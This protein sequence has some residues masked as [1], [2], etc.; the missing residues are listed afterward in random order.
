MKKETLKI[1]KNWKEQG[2]GFVLAHPDDE[3][4]MWGM[5]EYLC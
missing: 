4:L 1:K 3:A 5:M 2:V